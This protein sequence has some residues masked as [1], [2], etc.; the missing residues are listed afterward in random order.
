MESIPGECWMASPPGNQLL[1]LPPPP[2]RTSGET[3]VAGEPSGVYSEQQR[4]A[5]TQAAEAAAERQRAAGECSRSGGGDPS[6][7]PCAE[8]GQSLF[9][10]GRDRIDPSAATTSV[11]PQSTFGSFSSRAALLAG[12]DTD[13]GGW[14]VVAA[15]QGK[16]HSGE[17]QPAA[18]E[19][20]AGAARTGS[21]DQLAPAGGEEEEITNE[22]STPQP[23]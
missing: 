21:V 10:Q 18:A 15:R 16:G 13:G 11:P 17:Q 1:L 4:P 19:E 12:S 23:P 7:A 2:E 20:L 3:A 8:E 6:R 14:F 5:C 9:P 22:G